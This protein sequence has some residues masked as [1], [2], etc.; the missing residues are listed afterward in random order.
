MSADAAT[1]LQNP[2]L[3]RTRSRYFHF[4]SGLLLAIVLAGFA[5]SFFL[6]PVFMSAA[7]PAALL[8]HGSLLT[9][10]FVV[11]FTQTSLIATGRTRLHRSLG[12]AGAA[13]ALIVVV[14]GLI[15]TL[16][17]GR[18]VQS[19]ADR[20]H[21]IVWGNL[22]TLTAFTALVAAGVWKRNSAAAHRRLML[23]ASIAIIGPPLGRIP[24]WPGMPGGP[25]LAVAY[26]IGG[27]L[28]LT[29]SVIV[30]DL[31]SMRRV[32]GATWAGLIVTFA[33]IAGT[34]VLGTSSTALSVLRIL[35]GH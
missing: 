23:M 4:M 16:G 6:R 35:V 27:I 7:L 5:R 17:M 30:H 25:Q 18:R 15:A 33:S 19:L 24:D 2:A 29:G 31:R 10:W 28:L 8:L 20:E 1:V 32:H 14:S 34:V 26:A 22:L 3:S 12:Y 9:V 11:A 21:M 13:W